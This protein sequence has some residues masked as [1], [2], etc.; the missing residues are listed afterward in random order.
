LALG[1]PDRAAQQASAVLRQN[2]RNTEA[3]KVAVEAEIQRGDTAQAIQIIE[4]SIRK[5]A[6]VKGIRPELHQQL[7]A[8]TLA[9]RQRPQ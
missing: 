4:Q 8:D 9:R 3:I 2:P 7:L 1:N 6:T 5:G